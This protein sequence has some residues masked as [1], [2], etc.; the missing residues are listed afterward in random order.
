[1]ADCNRQ[2]AN[3]GLNDARLSNQTD[4]IQQNSNRGLDSNNQGWSQQQYQ[5]QSGSRG[6][7]TYQ[8]Q[9]GSNAAGSYQQ[10]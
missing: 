4:Q 6:A 8:Q 5:Q 3:Q 1:G 9:S 7:G 2:A 10:R